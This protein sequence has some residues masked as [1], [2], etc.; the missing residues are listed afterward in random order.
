MC[1]Q[2]AG[3]QGDLLRRAS[4]WRKV[5]TQGRAVSEFWR[6]RGCHPHLSLACLHCLQV[7]TGTGFLILSSAKS[8]EFKKCM[9]QRLDGRNR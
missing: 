5:G 3:G 7:G 8:Q 1:E 2:R 6:Q 9:C 4:G